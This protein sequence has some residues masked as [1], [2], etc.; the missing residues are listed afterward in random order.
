MCKAKRAE[1]VGAQW[2]GW[3]GLTQMNR[4][5][6]MSNSNAVQCTRDKMSK[7]STTLNEIKCLLSSFTFIP[8]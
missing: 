7:Y 2:V 6:I 8:N 1:W 3:V 5:S 4:M